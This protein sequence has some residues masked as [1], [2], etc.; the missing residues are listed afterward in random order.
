M[1]PFFRAAILEAWVNM[2]QNIK[3]KLKF[4]FLICCMVSMVACSSSKVSE[5]E[6]AAPSDGAE[7]G[8]LEGKLTEANTDSVPVPNAQIPE[9]VVTNDALIAANAQAAA[10]S[11]PTPNAGEAEKE[12]KHKNS[13]NEAPVENTDG[14]KYIVKKG[15]TLMKIAFINYGDLY[16]WKD[17]LE[18]NRNV[19]TDPNHIPPGT[20]L[21]LSGT[22][23]IKD[24]R[25]GEQYLVK[26][27]DTLQ[28]ISH[29]VYGT[30]R[31]WKKIW[32]NNRQY[33]K[34]PNQIYAGFYLFYLPES[35][36]PRSP[37]A[38]ELPAANPSVQGTASGQ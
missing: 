24:E 21:Q 37:A 23:I 32:E 11:A 16:R 19:I 15:D 38:A 7:A 20:E 3:N 28:T 10:A 26:H 8:K 13:K 36:D 4:G 5:G 6:V 35:H 29:D 27:G 2:E 12:S 14:V 9:P 1:I 30:S 33:L 34:N 22:G 25:Q 31:K 18:A 17:I